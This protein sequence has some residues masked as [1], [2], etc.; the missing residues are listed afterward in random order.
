M[1]KLLIPLIVFIVL[2]STANSALFFLDHDETLLIIRLLVSFLVTLL[3]VRF[4]FHKLKTI[5]RKIDPYVGFRRLFS[6][7]TGGAL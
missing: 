3:Y 4:A 1:R 2:F 5:L 6:D 7:E